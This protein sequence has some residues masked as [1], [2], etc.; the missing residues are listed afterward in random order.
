VACCP[1][2]AKLKAQRPVQTIIGLVSDQN[3]GMKPELPIKL[4]IGRNLRGPF[5]VNSGFLKVFFSNKSSL[6]SKYFPANRKKPL[7]N[8]LVA[9]I[10]INHNFKQC[11]FQSA[12]IALFRL[13]F[14]GSCIQE[15][16]SYHFNNF[17]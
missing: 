6:L 11:Y 16:F 7:K 1:S 17:K 8:P 4:V 5:S 15:R 9:S 12:G 3:L 2:F 10:Q 13:I 14:C